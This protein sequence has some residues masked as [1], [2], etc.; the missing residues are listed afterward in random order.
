MEVL[1]I[2]EDWVEKVRR[3]RIAVYA[4]CDAVDRID[5]AGDLGPEWQEIDAARNEAERARS[6]LLQRPKPLFAHT[7]S[8]IVEEVSDHGIAELVLG[9]VGQFGG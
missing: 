9:D 6:A 7:T 1:M 4:Y 2:S 5:G 8:L 3:Y